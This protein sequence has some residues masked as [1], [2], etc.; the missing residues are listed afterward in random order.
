MLLTITTGPLSVIGDPIGKVAEKGLKPV[1]SLTGNVGEPSG[2]AALEVKHQAIE[3][4]GGNE[5]PNKPD[6]EKPGKSA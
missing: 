4:Q 1:G 3:E 5:N 2:E 6:S